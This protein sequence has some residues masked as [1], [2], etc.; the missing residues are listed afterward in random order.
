[1]GDQAHDVSPTRI[2]MQRHEVPTVFVHGRANA[3]DVRYVEDRLAS[4][5]LL[6]PAVR[7]TVLWIEAATVP[8]RV[9]IEAG[10][11][12]TTVATWVGTPVNAC[13]DGATVRAAGDACIALMLRRLSPVLTEN[14]T[15]G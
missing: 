9:E 15:S 6:A 10:T 12:G 11:V 4:A 5:L 7:Y 1:M 13:C 8:V 3:P 2:G 14:G